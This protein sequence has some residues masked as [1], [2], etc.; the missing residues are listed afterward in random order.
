MR[1]IAL[2]AVIMA[3]PLLAAAQTQV[4]PV[5]TRAGAAPG[6]APGA[7]GGAGPSEADLCRKQLAGVHDQADEKE[8]NYVLMIERIQNESET[9]KATLIEWLKEAQAAAKTQ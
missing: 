8:R 9:E 2:A 7:V 3:S 5:A 1:R 6:A 4:P